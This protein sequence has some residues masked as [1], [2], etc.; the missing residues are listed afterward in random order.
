MA[1]IEIG[2]GGIPEPTICG[3]VS[4]FKELTLS[5]NAIRMG[6]YGVLVGL[7]AALLFYIAWTY[8]APRLYRYGSD[9]GWWS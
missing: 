6:E 1:G 8:A 9:R 2:F 3:P 4:D 7:A 5:S